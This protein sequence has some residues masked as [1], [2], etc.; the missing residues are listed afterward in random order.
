[1]GTALCFLATV[2]AQE[3]NIVEVAKKLGA[4]TLLEL[5][6][7]AGLADVLATGGPF[8]VFAPTNDAFSKLPKRIINTLK[9]DKKL[10]ADVLK[11][12]VV[13]GKVYS[14]AL[15]NDLL[16]DSLLTPAKIRINIYQNG[17]VITAS[18]SPVTAP[19]QNATNGVIHVVSKVLF[20]IPLGNVVQ[21][22][23]RQSEL[24]TLVKAVIAANLA[25]TLS[26]PG[27][28]TVL[29][30][31]DEAFSKL[32]PGTLDNLLKNI[33][34]LTDVLTYHVIGATAYSAGLTNG[35]SVPTVEGKSV[36]FSVSQEGVMIN[37]AAKV[38]GPD[39]SVT[40]GVIHI[41]DAVLL[42]K[43]YRPIV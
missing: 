35:E 8:T 34:A 24:G 10:L 40:N 23:Q 16:A 20:P 18:G 30:P 1:M 31:T 7:D 41:I 14:S 9:K 38:V 13:S 2:Y 6:T 21:T 29:A 25:S 36:T 32:P 4:T 33:T 27:P 42:P 19:D 28:F 12:H 26:G 39:E 3:G 5:A 37:N 15:K 17:K 43:A 22:A 11:Y